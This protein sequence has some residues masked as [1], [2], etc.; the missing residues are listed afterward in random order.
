LNAHEEEVAIRTAIHAGDDTQIF[1]SGSATPG[2]G[3]TFGSGNAVN[4]QF[5]SGS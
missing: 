3:S 4:G 2:G 1:G 5:G